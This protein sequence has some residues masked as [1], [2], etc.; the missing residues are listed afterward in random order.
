MRWRAQQVGFRRTEEEERAKEGGGRAEGGGI[1]GTPPLKK[2]ACFASPPSLPPRGHSGSKPRLA[3]KS[4]ALDWRLL[5]IYLL[6]CLRVK[7]AGSSGLGWVGLGLGM[8]CFKGLFSLLW[9]FYPVR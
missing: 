8:A 2:R 3:I 1:G 6:P 7:G 5:L 4:L 9:T